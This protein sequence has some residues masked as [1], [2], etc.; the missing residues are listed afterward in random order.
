MPDKKF[1]DEKIKAGVE[2]YEE[3]KKAKQEELAKEADEAISA[4]FSAEAA[5]NDSVI[6][7]LKKIPNSKKDQ[8]FAALLRVHEHALFFLQAFSGLSAR[9]QKYLAEFIE[10]QGYIDTS[11][12]NN[13]F[14]AFNEITDRQLRRWIFEYVPPRQILKYKSKLP[15]LSEQKLLS[16]VEVRNFSRKDLDW[17]VILEYIEY[18]PSIDRKTV[19]DK[20]I[21]RYSIDQY[22]RLLF[23][24]KDALGITVEE[25]LELLF[26]NKN[27]YSICD[28]LDL[29]DPK[30]HQQIADTLCETDSGAAVALRSAALFK[31]VDGE[32]ILRKVINDY[33]E[34]QWGLGRIIDSFQSVAKAWGRQIPKE[35]VEQIFDKDYLALAGNIDELGDNADKEKLEEKLWNNREFKILI[36]T[37]RSYGIVPDAKFAERLISNDGAVEVLD[38]IKHF[39]LLPRAVYLE[40]EGISPKRTY[41]SL[42]HFEGL[43]KDDV[44]R[45]MT[46]SVNEDIV[47]KIIKDFQNFEGLNLDYEFAER[48][49]GTGY[50]GVLY[51]YLNQ[52][53]ELTP[54][55]ITELALSD[56]Q[57]VK[58]GDSDLEFFLRELNQFQS[59]DEKDYQSIANKILRSRHPRLLATFANRFIGKIPDKDF[60]LIVEKLIGKGEAASV[61]WNWNSIAR[62]KLDYSKIA[63]LLIDAGAFAHVAEHREFYPAIQ[64]DR[65]LA[66]KIWDGFLN[67]NEWE[68]YQVSQMEE[69]DSLFKTPIDKN[70]RRAFEIVGYSL[71]KEIYETIKKIKDGSLEK[72]EMDNLGVTEIGDKGLRQLNERLNAFK[73]EILKDEFDPSIMEKSTLLR[74]YFKQYVNFKNSQ[75]GEH[76]DEEFGA[77]L[78]VYVY[79]RR[80]RDFRPLP[81]YFTPSGKVMVL[82]ANRKNQDA[83]EY[84]KPFKDRYQSMKASLAEAIRMLDNKNSEIE[85]LAMIERIRMEVISNF[86]E[87]LSKAADNPRAMGNLQKNISDLETLNLNGISEFQENFAV[88]SPYKEFHNALRQMAFYLALLKF[89][90]FK[91]RA[92]SIATQDEPDFDDIGWMINFIENIVNEETWG[93]ILNNNKAIKAFRSL[94]NIKALEEEFSRAQNQ[95]SDK[96]TALEFVPTRGILMEFSGHISDACWASTYRSIASAFPNFIAVIIRQNMGTK[97]ERLAGASMLIETEASDRT[98]LLVIRGLNPIENSINSLQ[99]QDFFKKFVEY[100][101]ELAKKGGRRLGIVIDDHS[102]G[103]ATNRPVLFEY[104]EGL[105]SELTPIRLRTKSDTTFNGYD[106]VDNTFLL[107]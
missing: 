91:N 53:Q 58:S 85:L 97:F 48:L 17:P 19:I 26:S 40:L 39:D 25:L 93:E 65:G 102:G 22:I 18:F 8:Y 90:N 98:P 95:K 29:I 42:H 34:D 78:D 70:F 66:E 74:Q 30:Y 49:I 54:H 37:C 69:I 5:T 3:E 76:G 88:L 81:E 38:N 43:N 7:Q 84:S 15:D 99:V 105:A 62:A 73:T 31:N 6:E 11:Q 103:S 12:I 77:I 80:R 16:L 68:L 36:T 64:K 87:K 24:K 28:S 35:I 21:S 71:T 104:L 67:C 75:F 57:L 32:K 23:I 56:A 106:I 41:A 52:F 13:I 20:I 100:A 96:K 86:R 27:F 59:L 94:T 1:I 101:K 63:G 51:K 55:V 82:Q 61:C 83:F 2:E 47:H 33:N 50:I 60:Q 46:G 107:D 14:N 44:F 72:D 45:A 92:R 4:M 9:S 79:S 89:E 10:K